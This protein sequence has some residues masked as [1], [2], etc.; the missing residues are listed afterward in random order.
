M[1]VSTPRLVLD[2]NVCLD[3]F[4]FADPRTAL[5]Y[6]ALR[7]GDVVGLTDPACRAE[8]LRVLAYPRLAL[9]ASRQQAATH[10]FDDCLRICDV[11]IG[12]VAE[13]R[14]LP[15]CRDPDD[16]KFLDLAARAG[17]RWLLSRDTHL[18]TLASR[19]RRAGLFEILQPQA[20]ADTFRS[21]VRK[22]VAQ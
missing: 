14:S 19:A 10:A 13:P 12:A 18:L 6:E 4:V 11:D 16:Q 2:T 8:W 22:R 7:R 3:V 20:W 1:T 5:L 17:A 9:E 21:R 15:R